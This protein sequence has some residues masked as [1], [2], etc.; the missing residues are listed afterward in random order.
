M[1]DFIVESIIMAI[2]GVVIVMLLNRNWFARQ[3]LKSDLR[4]KE[5]NYAYKIDKKKLKLRGLKTSAAINTPLDS[6]GGFTKYLPMLKSLD[7]DQI[8]DLISIFI[9]G[10]EGDDEVK[11]SGILEQIIGN[12][13]PE[14]IQSFIEGF[15]G[16]K[17][18]QDTNVISQV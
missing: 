14:M 6:L 9:G 7:G 17:K 11:P 13:P 5:M 2:N 12:V 15:V 4:E 3:K 10:E 16:K 1:G 8:Q 18:E